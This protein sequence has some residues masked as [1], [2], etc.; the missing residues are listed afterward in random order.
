M[1]L[2][3]KAASMDDPYYVLD[4]ENMSTIKNCF[5][6]T[7]TKEYKA[8]FALKIFAES[9]DDTDVRKTPLLEWVED[10]STRWETD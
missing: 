1:K 8:Y 7:P 2:S 3:D 4:A 9:L 6:L 10:L 5:V